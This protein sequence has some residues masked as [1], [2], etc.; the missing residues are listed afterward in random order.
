MTRIRVLL[1]LF[2]V[3]DSLFGPETTAWVGDFF[4]YPVG[5]RGYTFVL[6]VVYQKICTFYFNE[7]EIL[8]TGLVSVSV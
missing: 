4:F 6:T 3:V 2:T 5:L 7:I 1:L 8:Y